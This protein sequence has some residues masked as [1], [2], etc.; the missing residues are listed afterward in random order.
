[1][2]KIKTIFDRD[3]NG[4]RGVV[5]KY[6][7]DAEKLKTAKATEK[8][9]GTNIRLTI[10][11]GEVVRVEKR[12]NP[13]KLQ[14]ARGI[15]EPWYVDTDK[16][17]PQDKHIIKAVNSTIFKGTKDGEW[18][19]EAYGGKIQG[20]PLGAEPCVY[21]FEHDELPNIKD[22]PITFN[23]LKEWLPKQ[24]SNVAGCLIEGIV[25]HCEDGTMYKIKTKDFK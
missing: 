8:V 10:R 20:N 1:M 16:N 14:K 4:N 21:M 22:C 19:A 2:K 13:T 9:D 23:E 24:R 25:W 3:W 5:D 11:S 6:V 7:I 15:N 12:K 18:C 17:N